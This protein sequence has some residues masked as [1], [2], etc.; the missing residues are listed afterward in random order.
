MMK[1]IVIGVALLSMAS[2][3]AL[4]DGG[5]KTEENEGRGLTISQTF[6]KTDSKAESY[7]NSFIGC[8]H[9]SDE[10]DLQAA[11]ELKQVAK[12]TADEEKAVG[13]AKKVSFWG[14]FRESVRSAVSSVVKAIKSVFGF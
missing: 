1:N 11:K 9:I 14:S 3:I 5:V 4:A 13:N 7:S 12:P 2:T 8:Y 6:S 10:E